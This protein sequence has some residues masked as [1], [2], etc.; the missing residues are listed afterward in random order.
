MSRRFGPALAAAGMVAACVAPAGA[1]WAFNA[2]G[3]KWPQASMPVHYRLQ[4]QG[5]A[6]VTDGSDLEA[7]R[8]AF[9]TWESVACSFLAFTEQPWM[10]PIS[11]A[12]DGVHRVFWVEERTLWPGEAA[13]LAL[14]YTFYR[15][16][17]LVVTDAD[18]IANGADWEWTTV[19]GQ[20]AM[21]RVDV[22]TVMFHEIGHFFGLD[23]TSDPSAAMFP[24]NNVPIR[25]GPAN[26]DIAGVCTLYNNGGAIPNGADPSQAGTVGAPCRS[27]NDCASALCAEDTGGT[28]CTA[29]CT[30]GAGGCPA[31]FPCQAT[32]QGDYCLAPPAIDELCDQCNAG[33]Q[34][35][36]GLCLDVP[37][38]NNFQRFC[39]RACDPTPGGP[40]SCPN[41]YRCEAVS[42]G[43][44][45][46]GVCAP[47]TGICNP[48][49]R[50]GHNEPC[51]A[52]GGCKPGHTCIQYYP[53]SGLNFCYVECPPQFA[54]TSCSDGSQ[55]IQCLGTDPLNAF[56][57]MNIHACF[58]VAGV[59]QPCIPEVCQSG[60]VCAFDENQGIDTAVC[61]QTCPTGQCAVNTQC[62]GFEGLGNVCV[63]NAGFK[64]LGDRCQ[65][66]AEC[67]SGMCRTYGDT[68]LCTQN[69]AT[70][71]P[72][73]CSAGLRCIAA[74]DSVQ[75]LCW[76]LSA[77]VPENRGGAIEPNPNYCAC[78][79]TSGCDARCD[80]DPECGGGCSCAALPP[81]GEGPGGAL[82]GLGLLA[83]A[84]LGLRARGA[85]SRRSRRA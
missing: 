37:G 61:Y 57:R 54:N 38:Y 77:L 69:C 10:E 65:S 73:G 43:A 22:E 82:S 81:L 42:N 13:T 20:V 8:K 84:A 48:A 11:V 68:Q 67:Q 35:Q 44:M 59:G 55:R 71:D 9:Q 30:Q 7:L 45:T 78:D 34:C 56:G 23:H 72:S 6:D 4:P 12:N 79:F 76:P 51:F 83:L 33:T 2:P 62:I 75:G 1:A 14:T 21:R 19:E 15:T 31:Q 39:T 47:T 58:N 27:N 46:G 64:P 52:N 50:G 49:G 3:H 26:D 17:D 66:N 41:G 29:T 28:Y 80:C 16:T 53:N 60:A 74:A 25:R 63:P 70:T 36:S 5:T 40:P 24:Q 32:A 18:I 85:V